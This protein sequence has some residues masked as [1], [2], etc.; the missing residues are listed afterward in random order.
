MKTI[1][2]MA[3]LAL[4]AGCSQTE[5]AVP[6]N[7]DG[8]LRVATWNIRYFPQP[9][10]DL[11][12]TAEILA[13]LDADLIGVQE[14]HDHRAFGELLERVN[15][16]LAVRR[17]SRGDDHPP[18][19]YEFRL[20]DSGG[21]GGMYVGYVYDASA[22][23]LEEVATLDRLQ[24]TP[25]LRP[26]LFAR[27]RSRRGGLDFQVIVV[28][29]D[30]GV[31]DRDY[32]NRLRFLDSLAVEV[33]ARRPADAD[34][35]VL[36]DL[37]TMGRNAD[38]DLAAVSA[39]EE[40]AH[41]DRAAAGMGLRRLGNAPDCTEYYRG[42]GATLDHILVAIASEEAASLRVAAVTGYCA[43]ARCGRLDPSEMPY[44]YAYV[45]DHCPVVIELRDADSD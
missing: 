6:P 21:N 37:N 25:D 7:G 26:G 31:R 11:E 36:G 23:D 29:T 15:G 38:D 2:R 3:V 20:A 41:L 32:G 24:M 45:S 9:D 12:R 8:T 39:S 19:R 40:I 1:V 44:D 17:P 35:I 30:S 43:E 34:I 4:A 33:R 28:H 16:I 18:R 13:D 22:V 10:T 27:V 5:P 14:I 42:R